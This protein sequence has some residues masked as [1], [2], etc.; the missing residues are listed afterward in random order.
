MSLTPNFRNKITCM[1]KSVRKKKFIYRKELERLLGLMAFAGQIIPMARVRN[2][3]LLS[4]KELKS[5]VIKPR[6]LNKELLW[7]TKTVN[8]AQQNVIRSRPAN[9]CLWTDA[10]DVGYGGHLGDGQTF[11]GLWSK[12]MKSLHINAKELYALVFAVSSDIIPVDSSIVWFADNVPAVFCVQRKGS[13]RSQILQRISMELFHILKRKR[14]TVT[15][16]YIPGIRNVTADSL[17]RDKV[18]PSEWEMHPEAFK[19]LTKELGWT[20]QVDAMATPWNTKVSTFI[21]PFDHPAAAGVDFFAV[22]LNQWS[23]IYIFPPQNQIS[24]VLNHLISFQGKIILIAPYLQNQPWF[25]VL[26]GRT[27]K[28]V[29]LTHSPQQ[30]VQGVMEVASSQ[31]SSP[32]SAWIF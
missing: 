21:C 7:W 19:N 9:I 30:E 25:P 11:Q 29:Q 6:N 27:R 32:F 3:K 1:A 17:S 8:L 5:T 26:M 22:N 20:P 24:K 28:R 15:P 31:C 4:N 2:L 16:H 18:I 12:D 14:L 10:S 13:N 23:I